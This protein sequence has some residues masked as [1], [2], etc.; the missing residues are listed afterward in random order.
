MIVLKS[1]VNFEWPWANACDEQKAE[2]IFAQTYPFAVST[3][4]GV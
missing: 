4:E 2:A 3:L 1:S